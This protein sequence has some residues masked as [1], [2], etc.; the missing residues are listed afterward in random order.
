MTQSQNYSVCDLFPTNVCSF[1][2]SIREHK[3]ELWPGFYTSLRQHETNILM[4]CDI[5]FKFMR[6][7][8]IYDVLTSCVSSNI[9]QEFSSKVIGSIALTFYNNKT[10]RIDD[11]DYSMNPTCTFDMRDGTKISYIEYYKTKYNIRIQVT[12][13]I[14]Y[15]TVIFQ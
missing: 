15:W 12:I 2:V 9:K 10:Y 7:D 14:I 4:N 5:S 13:T 6:M 8:T 11:V 3:I 1:Q